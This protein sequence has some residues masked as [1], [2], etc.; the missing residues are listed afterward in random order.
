MISR[1]KDYS[2]V[3]LTSVRAFKC[4]CVLETVRG[5]STANKDCYKIS[6]HSFCRFLYTACVLDFSGLFVRPNI[7]REDDL[8]VQCCCVVDFWWLIVAHKNDDS[9]NCELGESGARRIKNFN[10]LYL[11]QKRLYTSPILK[12]RVQISV[13]NWLGQN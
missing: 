3:R 4:A 9:N 7:F 13:F 10:L 8:S 6:L 1:R 2:K 5:I 11:A 12:M